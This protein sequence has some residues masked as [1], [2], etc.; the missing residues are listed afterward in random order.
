M[1]NSNQS[2]WSKMGFVDRSSTSSESG[3][4]GSTTLEAL[5][6]FQRIGLGLDRDVLTYTSAT[7]K[8]SNRTIE[9]VCGV[10]G[11]TGAILIGTGSTTMGGDSI[12]LGNGCTGS[13]GALTIKVGT[14]TLATDL[15]TNEDLHDVLKAYLPITINNQL[16][17]IQLWQTAA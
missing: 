7:G 17:Y 16:F 11:A 9:H 3:G 13:G 2:Y 8:W 5:T 12:T 10:S 1:S 4:S 15:T 6:D 14:Q